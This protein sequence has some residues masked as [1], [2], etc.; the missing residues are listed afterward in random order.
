M[1]CTV[2]TILLL[3]KTA[4]PL[5]VKPVVMTYRCWLHG[6]ITTD[7]QSALSGTFCHLPNWRM[8]ETRCVDMSASQHMHQRSC[9]SP[10]AFENTF[11]QLSFFSESV[12][13]SLSQWLQRL[14]LACTSLCVFLF[15]HLQTLFL[16]LFSF[17]ARRRS[18]RERNK[19][20]NDD[21]KH[22]HVALQQPTWLR[23]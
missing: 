10:F 1:L 3:L 11:W 5:E 7:D 14:L 6:C 12:L 2:Q 9:D 22:G 13:Q 20:V 4:H 16:V 18:D 19:T 15:A 23:A 17:E 8:P 21:T